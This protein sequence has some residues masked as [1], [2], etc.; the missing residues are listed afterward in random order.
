M[1]L[2]RYILLGYKTY[3]AVEMELN[4]A[5]IYKT[6]LLSCHY[7]QALKTGHKNQHENRGTNLEPQL[8]PA[9]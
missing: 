8:N 2:H 7:I 4:Y 3:S 6:Q 9:V 5:Y 1:K